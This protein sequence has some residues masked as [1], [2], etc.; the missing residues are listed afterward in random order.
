MRISEVVEPG[1]SRHT[2][3]HRHALLR[4]IKKIGTV[5]QAGLP[6]RMGIVVKARS[7]K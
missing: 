7:L 5:Q 4:L 1:L 3:S 6:V 2:V